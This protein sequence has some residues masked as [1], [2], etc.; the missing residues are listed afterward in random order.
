MNTFENAYSDA[1]TL[2][3][4]SMTREDF[5]EIGLIAWN[6]IGNKICKTH[7][8]IAH[9]DECGK[10]ELP[11]NAVIVESVNYLHEDWQH[12]D[13]ARNM[14]NAWSLWAE[15]YIERLKAD[16]SHLYNKGKYAKY[17]LV[18][19]KLY[20]QHPC[21]V[22]ILY[23]GVEVDE[24]GLPCI[25]EDE[26]F[27]IATYAAYTEKFK[28]QLITGVQDVSIPTLRAE[29]DRACSHARVSQRVSQ[30]DMDDILDCLSTW[31]RKIFG[32]S[33]KPIA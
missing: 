20:F 32:K 14:G 17:E 22:S 2:Y 25:T 7:R 8:Y 6:K 11:C 26:S 9:T 4:I 27:A 31:N 5:D 23:K 24:D 15:E 21:I 12:V 28:N 10:I 3:A 29:W 1:V 19:D 18:G 13:E 16:T 30:N 33:F